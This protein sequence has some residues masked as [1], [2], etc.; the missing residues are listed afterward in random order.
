[1]IFKNLF[2]NLCSSVQSQ[3]AHTLELKFEDDGITIK[4]KSFSCYY[5]E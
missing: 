2:N 1:M 4:F 5:F 3:F